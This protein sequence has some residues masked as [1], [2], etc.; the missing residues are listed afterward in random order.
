M[1]KDNKSSIY[2]IGLSKKFDLM[3]MGMST[4]MAASLKDGD[5]MLAMQV[6]S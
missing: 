2:S 5:F 4:Y 3:G 1:I 6:P